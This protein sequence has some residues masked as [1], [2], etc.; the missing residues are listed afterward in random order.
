MKKKKEFDKV[1][2]CFV[3]RNT[4]GSE[5]VRRKNRNQKKSEKS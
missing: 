4:K 5:S 2:R 3:R 1:Y